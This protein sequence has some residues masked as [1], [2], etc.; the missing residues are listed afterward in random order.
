MPSGLDVIVDYAPV[1]QRIEQRFPNSRLGMPMRGVRYKLE[2]LCQLSKP[3]FVAR[4]PF[5]DNQ[6]FLV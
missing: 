5:G 3:C 2:L 6:C 4:I 1:A